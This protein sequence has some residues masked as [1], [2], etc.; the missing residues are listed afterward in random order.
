MYLL[1]RIKVVDISTDALIIGTV[2]TISFLV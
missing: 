2:E 1:T